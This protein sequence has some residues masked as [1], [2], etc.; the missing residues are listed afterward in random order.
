MF[1]VPWHADPFF[2]PVFKI[3]CAMLQ[4]QGTKMSQIQFQ[5]S[6]NVTLDELHT[7]IADKLWQFPGLVKLQY[8]L[9]CKAKTAF[10]S[11]QS[12]DELEIFIET[13]RP[14][15][16]P[17]CLANGKPSTQPMK[18]VTV[19]FDDAASEDELAGPAPTGNHNKAVGWTFSHISIIHSVSRVQ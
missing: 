12:N 11:I 3:W 13:V 15:I 1:D 5:I 10:T 9:D 17:P 4:S 8:W 7:V 14:L 16:V 18:P 6:S 2:P 19:Y